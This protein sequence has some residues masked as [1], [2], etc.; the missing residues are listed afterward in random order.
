MKDL[1]FFE[2]YIEKRK[3]NI[4]KRLI[5]YF[6]AILLVLFI[7]FYSIF[8]QIKIRRISKDV[9]KLRSIVEDEK[10]N[11]K[12]TE[13]NEKKKEVA[14]FNE[15]LDKIKLLDN[16][17]EEDNII[18]DYLLENITSRMPDDVFFTSISIYT[19]NIQIIGI[20]KDKWS[21]AE[22]GKSLG[23]IEEFKEIFITN[24]SFEEDNYNFT[25]NINL[26]DVNMDEEE[27]AVGE[28]ENE[29]VYEE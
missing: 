2:S 10:I 19:D 17:I 27:K 5:Y 29:E 18:D 15:S 23:S 3:F 8:N 11:K 26:K 12:V 13:I 28:D 24:I 16:V 1:N 21:I 22:L 9:G 25:L 14:K 7:V 20:S 6:I 4:D